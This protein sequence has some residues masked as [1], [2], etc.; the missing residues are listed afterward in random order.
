MKSKIDAAGLQEL[1]LLFFNINQIQNDI[2]TAKSAMTEYKELID[3]IFSLGILDSEEGMK[4]CEEA[5]KKI[6][7]IQV[8]EEAK[9]ERSKYYAELEKKLGKPQLFI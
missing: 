1:Y 4:L 6:S 5:L 9:L 7:L 2:K 3:R 8:G